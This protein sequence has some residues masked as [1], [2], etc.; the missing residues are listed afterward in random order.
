M[1]SPV[2]QLQQSH[3]QRRFLR[4]KVDVRV[5]IAAEQ[6]TTDVIHGRCTIIGEGGFGA[7]LTAELPDSGYFW[8]EF[9]TPTLTEELKV[10][11]NVRQ[12]RGF[13]YGFQFVSLTRDQRTRVMKIFAQGLG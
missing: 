7:V 6:N 9:R 11:V 13:Q 12:K 1:D 3:P 10:R 8:A 5:K 4:R 2:P